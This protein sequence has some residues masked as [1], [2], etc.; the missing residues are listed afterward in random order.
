MQKSKL[1]LAVLGALFAANTYAGSYILQANKWG[2]AQEAAVANAGGKVRYASSD[3]GVAVID[4]DN[5]DFLA[6]MG[7]SRTVLSA[8]ADATLEFKQPSVALELQEDAVNPGIE[9]FWNAQWAPRA[10]DAPGA[11]NAG[12]TGAGVRVAVI[13]GGIH[14]THID[15][16][17]QIDTA[18]SISFVP[19]G[20]CETAFNCDVGT[21]WHATHVSGIIA[22][23]NN[24]IGTIGIAPNATIVGVKALHN[25]TGS[26]GSVIAAILYA[27][28]QG[29]AG[30]VG[31]AD[32]I[33][34]SLG[35][36]FP[37]GHRDASELTTA[38]N[39]AV[40][41]A[42]ARGSLVV[43]AA[44]NDA[45]DMDKTRNF[46]SV[47]A[48]SGNAIAISATGPTGFALG[49]TDFSTPSS[50]TNYGNSIVWVSATGGNDMLF[51]TS[52]GNA[53]CTV[54]RIPS[55][56]IASPCW[57]F[58]LV[59]APS[60]GSGASISSYAFAEGTSMAA[61]TAAGVAALIKQRFPNA[62]PAQLKTKLAQ[63]ATDAGKVGQDEFHGRGF[64]NALR[65]VTQ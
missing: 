35:A 13:D 47:P 46:I 7:A 52:A 41:F 55:G 49:A 6:A 18:H 50:Y 59:I 19:G 53:T 4:S 1:A 26:F 63:S 30:G 40:N 20:A 57:V 17:G 51:G 64:V 10:I 34:M 36:V 31:P 28:T 48:E 39:R 38:L 27:A 58:D 2:A 23:K 3:A 11:W 9:T 44:G 32:V 62:S 42:T 33:N 21:F 60:R 16:A 25:G 45:L 24:G 15:L 14:S 43:V 37:R 5:P 12:F 8:V 61:P 54:P 56:T 29:G 65:A 22:A